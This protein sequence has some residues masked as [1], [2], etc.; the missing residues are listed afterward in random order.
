ML[1]ALNVLAGYLFG[2]IPFGV[3][4]ARWRAGVDVRAQGSGNI[5]ATN[6]A[7]VA[8]K[9]LGAVVLGLD[10]GKAALPVFAA[11][12]LWP[13]SPW[14]HA[15][16]AV[17]A[18]LG[19]VFPPWLKFRGGKGVATAL[20]GLLVLVPEAAL[21]GGLAYILVV[22]AWKK[23]SLGSLVGG[24]LAVVMAFLTGRSRPYAYLAALLFGLILFT[25]RGNIRRLWR[26][27]ER[28]F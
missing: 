27:T 4:L 12:R 10:A 26:R 18:F 28:S 6:V 8:G 15:A 7:R 9:R 11:L 21:A 14:L 2:S 24:V 17:S 19:H 23:S 3:L 1:P 20:G 5:G 16:V 22:G 25:H 13:D